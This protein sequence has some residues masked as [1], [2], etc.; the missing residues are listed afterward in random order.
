MRAMVLHR[1]KTDLVLEELPIP[2][3]QKGQVLIK[4]LAC[5]G[6]AAQ[7]CI[8]GGGTHETKASSSYGA[9]DHWGRLS[10]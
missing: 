7:T 6:Y 10:L 2:K 8:F 1:P 4:V 3:P 5:G 9:P